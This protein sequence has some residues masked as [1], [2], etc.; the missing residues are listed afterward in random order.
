MAN[1]KTQSKV[2]IET[3]QLQKIK[4]NENN[5]FVSML[6]RYTNED[7]ESNEYT[8]NRVFRFT[9]NAKPD[10]IGQILSVMADE[11]RE[12]AIQLWK[13]SN[14]DRAEYCL[15]EITATEI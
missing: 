12:S 7:G 3:L 10:N 2:Q 9:A 8:K 13:R 6:N 1:K 4:R 11:G 5:L 15:D 14:P